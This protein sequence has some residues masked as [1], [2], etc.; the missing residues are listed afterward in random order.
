MSPQP[1]GQLQ[2]PN[3]GLLAHPATD[4]ALPGGAALAATAA[5]PTTAESV[6]HWLKESVAAL[7]GIALVVCLLYMIWGAFGHLNAGQNDPSFDRI[8]DLLL[9]IN[10]LVGVVIGYYFNRVSTEARAENAE[11]TARGA[12]AT[13]L[14]AESA[15][16]GAL[17]LAEQNRAEAELAK[18]AL[19]QVVPAAETVLSQMEADASGGSGDLGVAESAAGASHD[20]LSEARLNLRVALER[21]RAVV[22]R[23]SL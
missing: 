8:K 10:P 2:Q 16:T 23:G 13:A 17:S 22:N 15:R 5:D 14:Q 21:A 11:R 19:D 6:L 20:P 18:S 7:I 9:F 12:A 3:A 1:L 4:P